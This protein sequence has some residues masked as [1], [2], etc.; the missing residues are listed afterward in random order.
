MRILNC[1]NIFVSLQSTL[2]F[3]TNEWMNCQIFLIIS[4]GEKP[5]YHKGYD[6]TLSKMV[7]SKTLYL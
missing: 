2:T 5:I 6:S 1:L 4:V 3:S 7:N